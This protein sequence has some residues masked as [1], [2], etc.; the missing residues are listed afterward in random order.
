MPRPR[1]TR[2]CRSFLGDRVFKPRSI[3]MT[4]LETVRLE[5]SELEAMRLC[6]LEGLDQSGAGRQ[7]GVSRGTIQRLLQ[8]GRAKLLGSLLQNSAL[9]IEKGTHDEDLHPDG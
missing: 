8:S 1:K 2:R 4:E 6:D 5:L 9:V 7:M 3:P